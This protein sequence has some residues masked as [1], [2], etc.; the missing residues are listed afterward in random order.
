MENKTQQLTS[1]KLYLLTTKKGKYRK[2]LQTKFKVK[3][4]F[5][6]NGQPISYTKLDLLAAFDPP[7]NGEHKLS[8]ESWRKL[9]NLAETLEVQ[10]QVFGSK[11]CEKRILKVFMA[12]NA[13]EG[14]I[15]D[16]SDPFDCEVMIDRRYERFF[17]LLLKR[18]KYLDFYLNSL[19]SDVKI[20]KQTVNSQISNSN[21]STSNAYSSTFT[22]LLSG[23]EYQVYQ[24][25][26]EI[27]KNGLVA[28]K[29]YNDMV[30]HQN[31]Y[32]EVSKAFRY[33]SLH[34]DLCNFYKKEKSNSSKNKNDGNF[35]KKFINFSNY[36]SKEEHGLLLKLSYDIEA[37]N[38]Q[39]IKYTKNGKESL[40]I[41]FFI[42]NHYDNWADEEISNN[43]RIIRCAYGASVRFG[44]IVS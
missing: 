11:S 23:N 27:L 20:T 17:N 43:I 44:G 8:A 4:N 5:L 25:K 36:L 34:T 24:C 10:I 30:I 19:Y 2:K 18:K 13:A 33:M 31:K 15:Y 42:P 16:S 3:I 22:L 26:Q 32:C 29:L 35:S 9:E 6:K 41:D 1:H 40:N 12:I 39:I 7:K 21:N 38:G 37:E 28:A 14:K